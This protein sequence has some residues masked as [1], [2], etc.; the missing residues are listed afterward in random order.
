MLARNISA[1]FLETVAFDMITERQS[2][3][4]VHSR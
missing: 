3:D 2:L 1:S 4:K